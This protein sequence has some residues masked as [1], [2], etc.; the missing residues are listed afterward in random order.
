MPRQ[1]NFHTM[2]ISLGL[3]LVFGLVATSAK[4]DTIAANCIGNVCTVTGTN[5]QGNILNATASFTFGAGTINLTLTNN[6]TNAQMSSVNQAITGVV[7]TLSSGQTSG[8]LV[9]SLGS[10]T[11]VGSNQIAMPAGS[12]ST[13][14]VLQNNPLTACVICSPSNPTAPEQAIIGGTGT[15]SYP[16][17]NASIAGNGAHNPFLFGPVMFSLS[18]P[19]VTAGTTISTVSIRFNTDLAETPPGVPEPTSMLLLGTGLIGLAGGVRRR[20]RK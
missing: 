15:G 3:L 16:N 9:S 2:V 4:A 12:G 10:F 5:S 14:W 17:A 1:I 7:F 11:N 20:L 8:T 6:L 18:V 13:G 19:G